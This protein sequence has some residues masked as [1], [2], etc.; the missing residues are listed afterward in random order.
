MSKSLK[1]LT[2]SVI[3][4]ALDAP[5]APSAIADAL[6]GAPAEETKP[7]I[8]QPDGWQQVDTSVEPE[9][10]PEPATE[11]TVIEKLGRGDRPL[12]A[13]PQEPAAEP[14]GFRTGFARRPGSADA[15]DGARQDGEAE[16]GVCQRVARLDRDRRPDR[17]QGLA[18][19]VGVGRLD[20]PQAGDRGGDGP[21]ARPP[22]QPDRR[23]TAGWVTAVHALKCV[24]CLPGAREGR[25]TVRSVHAVPRSAQSDLP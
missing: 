19:E 5:D 10:K 20:D 8:E 22:P 12:D 21:G 6:L 2:Q 4:Q 14:V 13:E 15:A 9:T 24:D 16:A 3:E 17:R 7:E 1:K 18:E 11:L 23:L 25:R